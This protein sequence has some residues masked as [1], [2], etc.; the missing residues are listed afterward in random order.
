MA[1]R[2]NPDV[3]DARVREMARLLRLAFEGSKAAMGRRL[4][5]RD[6]SFVGQMLRGDKPITETTWARLCDLR[7]VKPFINAATPAWNLPHLLR[8]PQ[9]MYFSGHGIAHVDHA[10]SERQPIVEPRMLV[11]EDLV[12]DDVKGQFIMAIEGDALAPLYLPGQSGIW[13]A[14][15]AGKP[16]Q[17]VLLADAAG[18]FYLRLYEPRPGGS[19]AGVSQRA[20]HTE[21]VPE[22]HGVR[23]VA[24][25]R[26]LDL[27]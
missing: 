9:A 1:T 7:E 18:A 15:T 3:G 26:Y 8:E 16:G 24:R 12:V 17:P 19:W 13:E 2:I 6:G 5:Y 22:L 10:V 25:M 11:W 27:G 20:G 21:L 4:G 14:G 23:V